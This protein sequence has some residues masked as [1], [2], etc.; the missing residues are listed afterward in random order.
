MPEAIALSV[1]DNSTVY[2]KDPF[3]NG[4]NLVLDLS[5]WDWD[6]KVTSG[7]MEDYKLIVESTVLSTPYEASPA[8]M[9]PIGGGENYSTF[10]IEIP[11][12]NVTQAD[13]NEYWVIAECANLDYSNDF[14]VQNDAWDDPLAAFFRY[15][16]EAGDAVPP[17]AKA[18]IAS[19]APYSSCQSVHFMDDGSYDPDGTIVKYEWDWD[20]NGTFDE[21]GSD[22]YHTFGSGGIHYVQFRVTD[23]D[24]FTDI[25]DVAL[26]LSIDEVSGWAKTWGGTFSGPDYSNDQSRGLAFDSSGNVYVAGQFQGTNVD[27]DPSPTGSDPHSSNGGLDAYLIKF[28]G[29]GG[30]IWARTWG[31][32]GDDACWGVI[33]DSNDNVI[34]HGSFAGSVDFD[35]GSSSDVHSSVGEGDCYLTKFDPS[36]SF[37]WART[38]GAAS[39]DNPYNIA[40]GPDD[41]IYFAGEWFYGPIDLNPDP[42][43]Y[44]VHPLIGA[45]DRYLSKFD[46]TGDYLWG[47]S[48]GGSLWDGGTGLAADSQ[49]NAY[50]LGHYRGNVDFDPDPVGTDW[51]SCVNY[52]AAS[53]VVSKFDTT[54]DYKWARLLGGTVPAYPYGIWINESETYFY[55]AGDLAGTN[56]DFDPGPGTDYHSSVGGDDAFLTVYDL[57]GNF[58]WARTW[59]GT[60]NDFASN[61]GGDSSGNIVVCGR[62]SSTG[63]DFDPG[64]GS[65][66]RSTNGGMDWF[67]SKFNPSGTFQWA[68]TWGAAGDDHA[69]A[70]GWDSCGGFLTV[71]FFVNIVDFDPGSGTD[72]HTAL[73]T[74]DAYLFRIGSDGNW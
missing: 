56:A 62:F 43:E 24:G 64:T 22:V 2:Y 68:R 45:S 38:W 70:T 20:N 8:D 32:S 49:G 37:I 61:V 19:S 55:I 40:L 63:M 15:S 12:D 10:H 17:V 73:G 1:V 69:L 35:P 26:Q 47:Q 3:T 23:N 57:S 29:S 51:I 44:D 53:G 39:Y 28:D 4:G 11:A 5:V 9:T 50:V 67:V 33:V 18:K 7:V 58:Q 14:N 52:P 48:W 46:S 72:N 65:D 66:P 25:L 60:N 42:A 16:L 6:S 31:G 21:E 71:G 36:G 74:Q 54:G 41:S 59:G 13:G 30:F 27:L 34:V